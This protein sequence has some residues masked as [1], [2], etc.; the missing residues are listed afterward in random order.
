VVRQRASQPVTLLV[1]GDRKQRRSV[2]RRVHG[3]DDVC[4]Q[5]PTLQVGECLVT[6]REPAAIPAREHDAPE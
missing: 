5:R 4:Q 3:A 2:G 6:V 1:G